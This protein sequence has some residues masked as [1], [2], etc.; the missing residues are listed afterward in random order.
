MSGIVTRQ[1]TFHATEEGQITSSLSGDDVTAVMQAVRKGG[2]G[3]SL[4]C[5]FAAVPGRGVL[6]EIP[7]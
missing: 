4:A 6:P 3:V 5:G 1:S 7:P 2:K